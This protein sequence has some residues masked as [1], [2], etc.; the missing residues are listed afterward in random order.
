MIDLLSICRL[1]AYT[2]YYYKEVKFVGLSNLR[3]YWNESEND[4]TIESFDIPKC[5]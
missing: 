1:Y 4:F 3:N 2:T 5:Y